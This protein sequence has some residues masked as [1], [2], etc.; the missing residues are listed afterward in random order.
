MANSDLADDFDAL[1]EIVDA[2]CD[3]L[4]N[5]PQTFNRTVESIADRARQ[6]RRRRLQDEDEAKKG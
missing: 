2:L 4:R 5:N 6:L 1:L 3:N